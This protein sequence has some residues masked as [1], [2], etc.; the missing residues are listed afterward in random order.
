M[1]IIIIIIEQF[2]VYIH[3]SLKKDYTVQ[4]KKLRNLIQKKI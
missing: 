4:S 1:Y 2:F 3:T